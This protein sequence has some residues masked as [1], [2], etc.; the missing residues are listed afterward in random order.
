MSKVLIYSKF[1]VSMSIKLIANELMNP[2][3]KII[4]VVAENSAGKTFD[5]E[6]YIKIFNL[7]QKCRNANVLIRKKN[8]TV[9]NNHYCHFN[10]L[11]SDQLPAI[12]QA[13]FSADS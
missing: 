6:S 13:H 10:Q 4:P 12:C 1:R 3:L 8:Q 5:S 7:S 9:V 11:F 2:N